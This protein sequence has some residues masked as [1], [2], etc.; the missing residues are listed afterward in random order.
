MPSPA[1]IQAIVAA[2][3]A[4]V[5]EAALPGLRSQIVSR[6]VEE[7]QSLEPAPGNRPSDL[8]NAAAA[9]I[10]AATSQAEILRHLLEGAARFCG[11]VAFVVAPCRGIH[12]WPGIAFEKYDSIN[13]L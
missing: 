3:A 5:F 1:R 4:A 8:L 11:R 7:L 2:A 13:N 9:S 10:Q 6:T 12:G